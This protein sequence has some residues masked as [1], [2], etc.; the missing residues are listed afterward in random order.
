[1]SA[2]AINVEFGYWMHTGKIIY[3]RPDNADKIKYLDWLY[4]LDYGI[5]PINNIQEL[6]EMAVMRTNISK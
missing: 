1:M 5:K 4:E 6:L 2:F 3:G